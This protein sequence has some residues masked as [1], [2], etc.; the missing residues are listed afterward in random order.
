MNR[1]EFIKNNALVAATLP[2]F[3]RN[4]GAAASSASPF[5]AGFAERDITPEIG[6]EMP[7]GYGKAYLKS[8]HDPC[9]IRAA[10]F[11][12]GTSRVAL[13]GVDALIV[14]RQLV[15]EARAAIQ[16]QCGIAPAAILIGASHSHSSG[17]VG[18]VQ[19]G[20]FDHASDLVKQLAYEESS[21]ANAAYLQKVLRAVVAGVAEADRERVAARCG[22]GFGFED[23]VSFNRRFRMSN[24][25]TYTHPGQ[26]NPDIVEPAGPID[27]QVG[28]LGAWDANDSL[29]GCIVNFAC[30]ATTNPGGISANWIYYMEK[31]LQAVFGTGVPVVFLQGA[32]AD[33]TQVDNLSPYKRR[34]GLEEA[35]R[36][37][38]R[39]GAEAVKAL[40]TVDK[41]ALTPV[42][43]AS[44]LLTF[45]RRI[46]REDR[47]R[48]CLSAV[49]RNP[50]EIGKTEWTFAKEIVLLQALIDQMPEV[51]AE[52]QAVQV[53]PAVFVSNPAELFCQLG[54]DLK[55]KSRFPFTFPVELGNGSVGYVPTRE[56]LGEHGGGYET[57]LTSYSNLEAGAGDRLVKAGLEL[58]ERFQP[59][60]TPRREA[61]PPFAGQPG[62]IGGSAWSYGNVPPELD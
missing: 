33:V 3:P 45:Q 13:V 30:H 12:D 2:G 32:C 43:A 46:P 59:G 21:C 9:K 39:V 51:Q 22:V 11:D 8:F 26:G 58:T 4:S 38:G 14:P 31:T 61:A 7:G 36:V 19:P 20:E 37:G 15:V 5:R 52:V 29:I 23:G 35:K 28:V 17:P 44:T 50:D 1:R 27:P 47:V 10:V 53:G 40:L 6:M 57:R 16:N 18:M 60:D 34:T 42:G 41:G 56:A 62:A 25:L 54:L 24:G 49:R 48:D 55:A